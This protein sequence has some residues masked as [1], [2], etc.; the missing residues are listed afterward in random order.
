M[1][2]IEALKLLKYIS[3]NDITEKEYS[4]MLDSKEAKVINGYI[5]DLEDRIDKAIEYLDALKGKDFSTRSQYGYILVNYNVIV[6]ILMGKKIF[7][8]K[9]NNR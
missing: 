8:Q 9:E 4:D 5:E 1:K 7:S 3:E 6:S 2:T